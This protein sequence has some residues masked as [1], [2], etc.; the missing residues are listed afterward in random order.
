MQD[1][2]ISRAQLV[3]GLSTGNGNLEYTVTHD[4]VNARHTA[5]PTFITWGATAPWREPSGRHC[6][7]D[8][9]GVLKVVKCR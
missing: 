1:T 5:V 8:C 7:G 2:P 4:T 9:F 3:N 6:P